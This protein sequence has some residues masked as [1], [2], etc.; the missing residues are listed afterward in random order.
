M[1]F[2]ADHYKY[3]R[4]SVLILDLIF[5]RLSGSGKMH[6]GKECHNLNILGTGQIDR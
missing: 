6:D 2:T 4:E 5:F 3:E 1:K